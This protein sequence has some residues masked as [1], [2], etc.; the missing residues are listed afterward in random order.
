MRARPARCAGSM[1]PRRPRSTA[2]RSSISPRST[3]PRSRVPTVTAAMTAD[4]RPATSPGVGDYAYTGLAL[5]DIRDGKIATI[6]IDRVTFNVAIDTA[7]KKETMTGEV[8]KLAAHDFDAA[9]VLAMLDPARAK[10]D[11]V[12]RVY[13]QM[14]AGGYT[15]TFG[16]GMRMR[17]EGMTADEIGVRPAKLQFASLMA[18]V[19]AAPPPGTTPTPA[20]TARP[21]REGR[22]PLRGRL[23]RQRRG[24]RPVDRDARRAVPARR[25]PARQARQRQARR[26]RA[27]RARC[28]R[29]AGAGEG[30]PLRA[31]VA[32]CREPDARRGSILR[33]RRQPDTGSTGRAGA[34]ARRHRDPGPGRALQGHQPAGQHRHAEPVVG[35]VRRADPDARARHAEDVRPGRPDR[36]R[37]VQVA[38]RRR[39]R[40]ARRSLSISAP[41]GP[42]ARARSRSSR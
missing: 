20:Q 21:V 22:G 13:R 24:A 28:A 32:R 29:A 25:D 34:A 11:K 42:R 33:L 37:A 1:P 35:P 31:Q 2:S 14:T 17:I 3:P 12:V 18:I 4:R 9:A 23:S 7:G 15:A 39:D 27:G 36:P 38:R 41:R 5:R 40:P 26:V 19:D 8:E 6:G 10:D 30:R 16:T